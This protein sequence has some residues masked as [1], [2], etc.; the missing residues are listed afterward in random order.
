MTFIPSSNIFGFS[1]TWFNVTL[2][3]QSLLFEVFLVEVEDELVELVV[4]VVGE[5]LLEAHLV[6]LVFFLYNKILE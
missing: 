1:V 2:P 4:D 6:L 5:P 3:R